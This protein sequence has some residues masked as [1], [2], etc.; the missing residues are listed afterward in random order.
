MGRKAKPRI[1]KTNQ[2]KTLEW[3][4]Q[5]FPYFQ[6][7]G[8]KGITMD[9]IAQKLNKSKT[10]LYDYFQTKEELLSLLVD[11]KLEQIRG[12]QLI[13][14]NNQLS[15][16]DRYYQS[17]EHLSRQIAGI[18]TQFLTDLRDLFPDLWERVQAFLDENVLMMK[19]FYTK[20]IEKGAFNPINTAILVLNDQLFFRALSNPDFLNREQ[21]SIQEAY[22]Q[23]MKLRFFGLLKK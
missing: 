14:E 21:I 17:M 2:N 9:S 1:R 16:I 4:E 7:S 15:F 8:L 13:L 18:S 3:L 10:T 19:E 11:I 22:E 5:L 20:G 6:E 23:Y 12:F